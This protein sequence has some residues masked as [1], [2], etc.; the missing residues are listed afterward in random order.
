MKLLWSAGILPMLFAFACS[1]VN[2]LISLGLLS[3]EEKHFFLPSK[4]ILF[5]S[6]SRLF[7][8]ELFFLLFK[9]NWAR[10]NDWHSSSRL[11]KAFPVITEGNTG[12]AMVVKHARM[13][14]A[15]VWQAQTNLF[16]GDVGP[17]KSLRSTHREILCSLY[18]SEKG[19]IRFEFHQHSL[20]AV[21]D[22]TVAKFI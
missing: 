5:L 1:N 21:G 22:V 3:E 8:R 16:A 18:L 15:A 2:T 19:L 6:L 4:T 13:I 14:R 11:E 9:D 20:F 12:E 10:W 17:E 7:K